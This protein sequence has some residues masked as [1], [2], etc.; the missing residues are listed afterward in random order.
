MSKINVKNEHEE[1][2]WRIRIVKKKL[3]KSINSKFL[4]LSKL[5]RSILK[6]FPDIPKIPQIDSPNLK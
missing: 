5:I 3:K 6:K 2:E 4:K 1:V